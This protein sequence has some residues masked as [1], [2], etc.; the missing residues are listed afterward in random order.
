MQH[1]S[2]IPP[3]HDSLGQQLYKSV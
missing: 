3:N 2:V 1:G